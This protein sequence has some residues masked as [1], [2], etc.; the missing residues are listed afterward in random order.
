LAGRG[1]FDGR[2]AIR[3]STRVTYL[4][5]EPELDEGA[6]VRDNVAAGGGAAFGLLQRFEA[7]RSKSATSSKWHRA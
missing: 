3:P 1:T 6:S 2:V 4:S 7:V 5:Q